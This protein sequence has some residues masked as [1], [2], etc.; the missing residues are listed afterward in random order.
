M[1]NELK[2]LYDSA[3]ALFQRGSFEKSIE[4]YTKCI[5]LKPD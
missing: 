4:E 5:K 1:E 3:Y 2:E